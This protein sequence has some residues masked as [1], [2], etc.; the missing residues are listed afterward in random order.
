MES[1]KIS[2]TASATLT[3]WFDRRECSTSPHK[4]EAMELGLNQS[5]I[6]HNKL[7]W[8]IMAHMKLKLLFTAMSAC[9]QIT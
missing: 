7:R 5:S 4:V 1:L 8:R 6:G 9:F 2:Y 3:T